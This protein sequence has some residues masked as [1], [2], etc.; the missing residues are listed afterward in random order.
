MIRRV[1][2]PSA[3]RRRDEVRLAQLQELRPHEA[4][5]GRP[6][7]QAD[8]DDHDGRDALA[9]GRHDHEDQEEDGQ[10]Q[11]DVDEAHEQVV[12]PAA[13]EAGD[14]ADGTPMR[15]MMTTDMNP[16]MSDVWSRLHQAQEDVLADLVVA[17]RMG[18]RGWH[19]SMRAGWS[20]A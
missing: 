10:R 12:D 18:Q 17:E 6:A 14:G 9:R 5:A 20:S 19:A 4:A 11:D 13:E 2:A 3:L 15:P 16:M 8:G 7:G 1:D